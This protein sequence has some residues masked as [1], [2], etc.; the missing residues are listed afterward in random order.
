MLGL[1]TRTYYSRSAWSMGSC[2]DLP[3]MPA[4]SAHDCLM[5]ASRLD[6]ALD[7]TVHMR[8]IPEAKPLRDEPAAHTHTQVLTL[9]LILTRILTRPLTAMTTKADRRRQRPCH[10]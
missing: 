3:Y 1:Q 7:R 4:A 5:Y 2:E 8:Q 6:Q 10:A 9:T